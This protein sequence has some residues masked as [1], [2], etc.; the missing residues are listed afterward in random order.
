VYCGVHILKGK[1]LKGTNN[2]I[3]CGTSMGQIPIN[4]DDTRHMHLNMTHINK[5]IFNCYHYVKCI[6]I[7]PLTQNTYH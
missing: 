4:Y 5:Y 3:E 1:K 6:F 7:V 2:T